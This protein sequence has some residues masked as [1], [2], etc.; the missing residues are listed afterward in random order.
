[1]RIPF[2]RLL[3]EVL[4]VTVLAGTVSIAIASSG[5][6][7]RAPGECLLYEPQIV[8]LAG[9]LRRKTFPGRPNYESVA[10]GD[11]AETG[12]Y[13]HLRHPVCTA[14]EGKD[15]PDRYPVEGVKIVQLVLD[16]AGYETL[17]PRLD[18]Q[19]TLRGTLFAAH[20]GHHHAALLLKVVSEEHP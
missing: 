3:V 4:I 18:H 6:A 1:M 20:T 15:W 13:L 2:G 19:V 10:R 12:F 16:S 14:G 5:S 8:S 17:R 11:E 7:G 9:T